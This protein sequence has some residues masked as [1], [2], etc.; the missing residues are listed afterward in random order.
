[1]LDRLELEIGYGLIPLVDEARGGDLLQR[2]GN[3]RRQVGPRARHLRPPDPRARQPAAGRAG[4]RDQAQGRGDRPRGAG[5]RPPA[6]D[7]HAAGRGRA[8]RAWRRPN[9]PS[10]CRR[11]GSTRDLKSNAEREGYTVVEPAAV[12]ATHLSE[13]IRGHADELLSRQ[14]VKDMCESVREF[15]PSLIE[16]LIPDKVPDQHAAERAAG[17][18]AR[19]HPGARHRDHPRDP[20]QLRGHRRR[21]PT[22]SPRGCARPCRARSP[23]CTPRPT[24]RIHV[25]SP[26]SAGASRCS[27]TACRE[28]RADRPGGPRPGLHAG[29][30]AAPRR[31]PARGL[32]APATPPVLLVPTPIRFFV[33]RLDR[34]DLSQPG[35]HGLHRGR[36]LGQD[37]GRRNGGDPWTGRTAGSRL[38]ADRW[39]Y[40]ADAPGQ[41][42]AVVRQR[43][44]DDAVIRARARSPAGTRRP[45]PGARSSRCWC[46]RPA[47]VRRAARTG[48]PAPVAGSAG[49][50][51]RRRDSLREVERIETLVRQVAADY[52]RGRSDAG[53]A[54][55]RPVGRGPARRRR[56]TAVVRR[57]ARRVSRPTRGQDPRDAGEFRGWLTDP[58]ARP[59]TAAG[60]TSTAATSSWATAAPAGPSWSWRPPRACRHSAAGAGAGRSCRGPGGEVRRLQPRR[61]AAATTPPSCRSP[62]N[63]PQARRTLAGYDAVLVD[64]PAW[65]TPPIADGGALHALAGAATPPST[66]TSCAPLDRDLRDR[67]TCPA[68]VRGTGIA[69]G[70]ASPAS[71][72]RRGPASSWICSRPLP[73]PVSLLSRGSG[74]RR[75]TWPSPPPAA[76]GSRSWAP[77]AA[78]AAGR[79]ARREV[80]RHGPGSSRPWRS[81][82]A[83]VCRWSPASGG[84][85][86]S[87]R[88]CRGSRSPISASSSWA[89]CWLAGSC[90]RRAAEP[91]RGHGGPGSD[92]RPMRTRMPLPAERRGRPSPASRSHGMDRADRAVSPITRKVRR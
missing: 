26:A 28:S 88:R 83:A 6:G 43:Y 84:T 12:L 66:A 31:R 78:P 46:S 86:A 16:D 32:R 54:V 25:V 92:A 74:A 8:R 48:S 80:R 73:L 61:P 14:D 79:T 10:T 38:T 71:T 44:G 21:A 5:S 68:P 58:A 89:P 53:L 27:S 45:R 41:P 77:T 69:T 17:A 36:P 2:I 52:E 13:I 67:A 22:S 3:L 75:R 57:A 70:S 39:W 1:M 64:T 24:A 34:T 55:A 9:P 47:P 18:A 33:K 40:G 62:S 90:G 35:R 56:S 15:A 30:P 42:I 20:G 59:A 60:T 29:V 4:V 72:G 51:H 85:R 19:A 65:T 37:P 63:S 81:A 7:E 50:R 82:A 76:A 91:G 87:W 11:S 49:G 23:P